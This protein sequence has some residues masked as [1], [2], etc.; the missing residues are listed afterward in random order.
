MP[1]D[2]KKIHIESHRHATSGAVPQHAHD[3]PSLIVVTSGIGGIRLG[4]QNFSLL[5]DSAVIVPAGVLHE[6]YDQ[7]GQPMNVLSVGF[8]QDSLLIC[9][10]SLEQLYAWRKIITLP[11]VESKNIHQLLRSMLVEQSQ[12]KFDFEAHMLSSLSRLLIILARSLNQ[13][14]LLGDASYDSLSKVRDVI[15]GIRTH[16]HEQ[17][18]LV[19]VAKM[20][21][22]SQRQFSN[23]CHQITGMNYVA[24][25]NKNRCERAKA[26]L[27]ETKMPVSA[28]A[29][30]VGFEELSTFYRAFKKIFGKA[31]REFREA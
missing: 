9:P 31:P 6:T 22:L 10:K 4:E 8:K 17:N 19:D 12:Q 27:L 3:F 1:L 11:I 21:H 30:E 15:D 16:S 20:A 7:P 2:L 25:V 13:Q 23:L 18:S 29:F 14:R 5:P 28:I 24:Y 26:L